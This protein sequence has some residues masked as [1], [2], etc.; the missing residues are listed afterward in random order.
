MQT[1]TRQTVIR[2]EES[3]YQRI[4]ASAIRQHRSLNSLMIS[5]LDTYVESDMPK[6]NPEDY[7]PSDELLNLGKTLSG[8]SL[9]ENNSEK[10]KYILAK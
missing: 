10:T 2:M 7:K 5:V 9:K 6:L 3:L 4:K 1:Q 8:I